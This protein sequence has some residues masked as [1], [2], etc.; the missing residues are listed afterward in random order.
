[1][2]KLVLMGM[3]TFL[4]ENTRWIIDYKYAHPIAGQTI[5]NFTDN[6]IDRYRGQLHH[7]ASLLR[8]IED[9]PIRCGLYLPRLPLFIEIPDR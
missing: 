9:Y 4:F 2:K 3:L 5:K 1:M 7:Y 6:M 8:G